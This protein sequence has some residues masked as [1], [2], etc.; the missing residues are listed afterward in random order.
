MKK[1][2][3]GVT[4]SAF[5]FSANAL[6]L[7]EAVKIALKN[8]L[9]IKN[10]NY[11]YLNKVEDK[12]A[13]NSAFL[14]KVGVS[15]SYK[16]TNEKVF[17]S[18]QSEIAVLSASIS[19][20][21]FNGL[22]HIAQKNASKFLSESSK[23]MLE[24]KKQDI[25]LSV[26]TAYINYLN[27]KNALETYEEAYKLFKEQYR[28]SKN[29]FKQGVISKNAL[30][31]IQVNMLK[32]KQNIVNAQ[33]LKKTAKLLLSNILGG[34]D[35]TNENI[36]NIKDNSTLVKYNE[37]FLHNRSEIKALKKSLASIQEQEK[38]SKSAYYP[39][40]DAKVAYDKYFD[41]L[42]FKKYDAIPNKDNQS[43]VSLS[44][45]WNLYNGGYDEA[46]VQK[47]KIAF[48]RAKNQLK[49]TKLDIKLQ[50]ENAKSKLDVALENLKTTRLSLVHA[51]ENYKIVKN[52]FDNGI[53]TNADLIDA[54][55]LL[56]SAKQAH[57]KAYFDKYLAL[58]TLDRIIEKE[59]Y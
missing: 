24:A 15:Y 8:N 7:D 4:L 30:L 41:T 19:Y 6:N 58:A 54:N 25:I 20:N 9:D 38:I 28:T 10:S 32:A 11:D 51:R 47:S 29:R 26:K 22:K 21:L 55:Y 31:Q 50:Y 5:M 12:D 1:I 57:D 43:S 59:K 39:R 27:A 46:Q 53:D 17:N 49:K 45:S 34:K 13:S 44:A 23:Y 35:L 40:V 42:S 56:S 36:K 3:L 18:G 14:P 2:I 52:R 48:L 37:N 16:G 33:G